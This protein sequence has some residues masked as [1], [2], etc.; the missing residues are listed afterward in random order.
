MNITHIESMQ[1]NKELKENKAAKKV[2][3]KISFWNLMPSSFTDDADEDDENDTL[4]ST[5]SYVCVLL[6]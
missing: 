3:S 2:E 4:K 6:N 5:I 1:K